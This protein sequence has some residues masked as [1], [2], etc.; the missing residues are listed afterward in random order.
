MVAAEKYCS[1]NNIQ[2]T[3]LR[4][5]VYEFLIE[6]HKA[7]GAYKILDMLRDAGYSSNPPIAYR[8]L[9]FLVEHGFAHKVEGLNAFVACANPGNSHLPAFMICRKCDKVAEIQ[10]TEPKLKLAD[11]S[12]AMGF[13]IEEA[14]IEMT[15]VCSSCVE[16]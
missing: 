10:D 13:E 6:D 8:V 5:K 1:S 9:D 12:R 3:P 7:V 4:R 2:L 15:G 11:P 16:I 14:I